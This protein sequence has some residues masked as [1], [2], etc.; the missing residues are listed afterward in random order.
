MRVAL[1]A[2]GIYITGALLFDE[3]FPFSRY[4][5][6]ADIGGRTQGAI[7]LFLADGQAA[8]PQDYA[9]FYGLSPERFF[10]PEG[11]ACS[12][13]YI[14]TERAAWV[15]AH[16]A[17]APGPIQVQV[18]FTLVTLRDG[19]LSQERLILQEGSAWPVE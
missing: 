8:E 11:V 17:T 2:C 13:N 1:L 14:V 7:P 10:A 15:G 19:G 18:G 9:A 3:L 16:P 12:L 5:M 4:A 6:Y